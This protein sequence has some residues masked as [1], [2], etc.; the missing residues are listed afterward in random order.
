MEPQPMAVSIEEAARVTSLSEPTIRR[1]I[2]KRLLTA[3]RCGR[4]VLVSVRSLEQ[5]VK[6]GTTPK[7]KKK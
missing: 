1:L 3:T 6:N 5:L 7:D 4:R 2:R